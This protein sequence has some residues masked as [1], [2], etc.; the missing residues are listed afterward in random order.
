MIIKQ[1]LDLNYTLS[2]G[3]MTRWVIGLSEGKAIALKCSQCEKSS[4]P[5][6]RICDCRSSKNEWIEL[7]GKANILVKTSGVDGDFAIA[8][9]EGSDNSAVVSLKGFKK[10]EMNGQIS[11]CDPS[12]P[13][14]NL[15]PIKSGN[16]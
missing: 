13:S 10:D 1:K 14:L 11:S 2:F 4:F 16:E 5:P 9:F 8:Q 7:S 6:Q 12:Q 3:K 15:I